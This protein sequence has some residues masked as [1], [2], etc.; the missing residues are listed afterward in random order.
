MK[1]HIHSAGL[2]VPDV[3]AA[4]AFW[5][6]VLGWEKR[7]DQQVGEGFRFVTVAPLGGEAELSLQQGETSSTGGVSLICNDLD[8]LQ[9]KLTA[10]GMELT[11]PIT[12]MGW[13]TRGCEFADPFGNRFYVDEG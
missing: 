8:A 5:V 6:N 7:I 9:E 12:A 2:P 11:M 13:G 4:I 3:D 10:H 1:M